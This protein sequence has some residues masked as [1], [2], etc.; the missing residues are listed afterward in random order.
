ML[1]SLRLDRP[2]QAA[3]RVIDTAMHRAGLTIA[4]EAALLSMQAVIRM[5]LL[6]PS[7]ANGAWTIRRATP[8]IAPHGPRCRRSLPQLGRPIRRQ[9]RPSLL[10]CWFCHRRCSFHQPLRR[11]T[12]TT[13]HRRDPRKHPT[14]GGPQ[15]P[16]A[17]QSRTSGE[18]TVSEHSEPGNSFG[19][20]LLASRLH[21]ASCT[22]R[23]SVPQRRAPAASCQQ[24][25]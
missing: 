1:E 20:C 21:S 10:S 7:R 12:S 8:D 16:I 22:R 4:S 15:S 14:I 6:F 25:G 24:C 9:R 2:P 11:L 13:H 19:A 17:N 23:R 3:S 18:D 5:Y